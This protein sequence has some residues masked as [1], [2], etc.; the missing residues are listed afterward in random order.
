MG[1][2]LSGVPQKMLLPELSLLETVYLAYSKARQ[3]WFIWG[4]SACANMK[5]LFLNASH[6]R[7]LLDAFYKKST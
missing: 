1:S 5:N 3:Q 7:C 4:F 6:E 2:P